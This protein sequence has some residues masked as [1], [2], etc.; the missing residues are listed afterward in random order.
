MDHRQF[1][2]ARAL[3]RSVTPH[4]AAVA[5]LFLGLLT[6]SL[7]CATSPWFAD[8]PASDESLLEWSFS[9][10]GGGDGEGTPDVPA[11]QTAALAIGAALSGRLPGPIDAVSVTAPLRWDAPARGPPESIRPA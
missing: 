8:A 6:L 5:A 4:R 3:A 11:L 1:G 7:A 2:Q 10:N 9:S